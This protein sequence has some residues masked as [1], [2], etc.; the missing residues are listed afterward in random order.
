MR[1]LGRRVRCDDGNEQANQQQGKER[2]GDDKTAIK[3]APRMLVH[4]TPNQALIH[5]NR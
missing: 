5:N 2:A 4:M 3:H 1:Q